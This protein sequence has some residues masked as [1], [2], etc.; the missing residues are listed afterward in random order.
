MRDDVRGYD[1]KSDGE[2]QLGRQTQFVLLR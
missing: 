1:G 2:N